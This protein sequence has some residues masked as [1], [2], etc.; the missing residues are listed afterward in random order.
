MVVSSTVRWKVAGRA[1]EFYLSRRNHGSYNLRWLQPG[2]GGS[3]SRSTPFLR[4]PL[5]SEKQAQPS[6][7]SDDEGSEEDK[8]RRLLKAKKLV[9]DMG[10]L[11]L[12]SSGVTLYPEPAQRAG[13]QHI[14]H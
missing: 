11:H 6:S 10:K 5:L 8:A 14:V 1:G 13:A 4:T 12:F 9:S 7:A 2:K 3:L